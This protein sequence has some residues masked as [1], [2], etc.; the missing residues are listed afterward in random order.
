MMSDWKQDSGADNQHYG[1]KDAE[2]HENLEPSPLFDPFARP[3]P[4]NWKASF[5]PEVVI[6]LDEPHPLG[7][8]TEHEPE[9][10]RE[11]RQKRGSGEDGNQGEHGTT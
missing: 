8:P 2:H 3:G 1:H 6:F 10:E 4:L 9:H 7:W 11:D 5:D